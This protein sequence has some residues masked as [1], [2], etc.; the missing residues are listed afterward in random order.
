MP[1]PNGDVC[2]AFT[3]TQF[4]G[5]NA[6]NAANC[7]IRFDGAPATAAGVNPTTAGDHEL[8]FSG[9]TSPDVAWTCWGAPP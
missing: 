6:S 1:K 2:Y 9:C 3:T 5:W 8:E 7:V 4:G